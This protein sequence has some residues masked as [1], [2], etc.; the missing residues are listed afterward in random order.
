VRGTF[1]ELQRRQYIRVNEVVE[2]DLSALAQHHIGV[3][4][5]EAVFC[6]HPQDQLAIGDAGCIFQLA[7]AADGHDEILLLQP[8]PFQGPAFDQ[9][10]ADGCGRGVFDRSA[11]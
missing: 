1:P 11:A 4:A 8:R 2:P 10:H 9:I 3:P 5:V 7:G 6:L